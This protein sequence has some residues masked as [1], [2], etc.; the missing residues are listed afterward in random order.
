MSLPEPFCHFCRHQE[1]DGSWTFDY[2][3][4]HA[5]LLGWLTPFFMWPFIVRHSAKAKA[6]VAE[7]P[8]YIAGGM[9]LQVVT[10][11]A[12]VV[13]ERRHTRRG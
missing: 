3:E 1:A 12:G 11:L 10:L 5:I 4:H 13:Y 7:E 6:L 9:F 2:D 8:W